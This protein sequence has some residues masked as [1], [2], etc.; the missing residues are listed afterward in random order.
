MLI[1][2]A[3]VGSFV[4]MAAACGPASV[5]PDSPPAP[6]SEVRATWTDDPGMACA[7]VMV[8]GVFPD[9]ETV[10]ALLSQP[11]FSERWR[12]ELHS[13]KSAAVARLGPVAAESCGAIIYTRR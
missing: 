8:D 5:T 2:R 10:R 4:I 7:L 11:D 12:M 3:L 1:P 13:T 6:Q 9:P